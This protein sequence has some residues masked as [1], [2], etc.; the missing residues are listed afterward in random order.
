MQLT[1]F[2]PDLKI[3]ASLFLVSLVSLQIKKN[4]TIKKKKKKSTKCGTVL[5]PT[6]PA[7]ILVARHWSHFPGASEL[8]HRQLPQKRRKWPAAGGKRKNGWKPARWALRNRG[9][10]RRLTISSWQRSRSVSNQ[11][12][13]PSLSQSQASLAEAT[14]LRR[15]GLLSPKPT[16]D[17]TLLSRKPSPSLSS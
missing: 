4:K 1:S 16:P 6:L 8:L 3:Y 12:G 5:V 11:R 17:L 2:L 13:L 15:G 10:A 9:S 14:P 7:N